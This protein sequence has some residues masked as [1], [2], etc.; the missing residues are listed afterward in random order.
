MVQLGFLVVFNAAFLGVHLLPLFVPVLECI[1]IPVRTV[2]CNWGILQ[3]NLSFDWE[4]SPVV[5]LA[6]LAMFIT[7]GVI[8]GRAMCGWAC[9]LGIT[10]DALAF[11]PRLF[12]KKQKEMPRALHHMLTSLKHVILFVTLVLTGSVGVAYI[13][14][15]IL[16]RRYAF[17]LGV[18]GHSPF[19]LVCPA[20]ILFTI[21]SFLAS[22]LLGGGAPVQ[23][24]FISI[25]GLLVLAIYIVPGIMVKR[26]WCRYICPSGAIMS[27]FNKLSLI[28][29]RKSEHKCTVFCRGHQRICNVA[30]PMRVQV[31]RDSEP[32]SNPECIFCYECA[33]ACPNKALGLKLG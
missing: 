6:S 12:K 15:K 23:I 17:S 20:P 24:P 13:F 4:V 19:C 7:L 16:G 10:Q 14:D 11:L 21:V 32:S 27:F 28:N 22:S 3:R 9:P 33:G 25:L 1:G 30:C 8:F 5:P 31:S 2:L 18:C 29:L 26:F